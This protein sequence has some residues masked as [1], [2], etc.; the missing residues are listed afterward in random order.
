[1][2][3]PVAERRSPER[4]RHPRSALHTA[5]GE[6]VTVVHL[7]AE[8]YPYARSGGLAEAVA[9]LARH[10]SAEGMRSLA[11]LP[12][13][14]SAREAAGP[15]VALGAPLEVRRNGERGA[16]RARLLWRRDSP[17]GT[18]IC[19]IEHDGYF[20]RERIYGDAH[21]D[22]PDNLE[23]YAFFS[24]AALE[25]LPRLVPGPLL[26]HAH[27][28]HASLGLVYLRSRY[29]SDPRYSGIA[30]VLSVHNAGY[31][32][33][34]P[35]QAM[36]E[37]G[38]PWELFDWR[39]LEWYGKVNVLKG[40]LAFADQ[41]VTV[42]PNHARELRTPGGGFGLQETFI[43]LGPRFSGILN[44]IDRQTWD[45]GSDGQIPATFTS[46]DPAGKAVCKR[47]VQRRFGLREDPRVP[48]FS[49]AARLV[50]QKGL[51][52]MLASPALLG[53][54]A[55]FVFIG[56][57]EA[58]FEQGLHA[59]AARHPDRI[60]VDTNFTDQ[61][62]HLLMAG[63]DFLLMPCQY[64]PC[65]LT[66]MRSQNY[67]AIPVV[68]RVGGLADTVEDGV[69]GFVFEP[70]HADPL[71]GA[72]LRGL[73]CYGSPPEWD[74]MRR[75]AMQRDFGWER[76]VERYLDVYRRALVRASPPAPAPEP[77]APRSRRTRVR[78]G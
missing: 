60:A 58:R 22:Y 4:A 10:Q 67:G 36:V 77:A 1:M 69:T 19:F 56:A 32:G 76:S 14:R 44:G 42:S 50:T 33:H 40:G 7:A 37:L 8:Y 43:W 72:V 71:L 45:P 59:L 48:L 41:V 51:D 46:A 34:Y 6:P 2:P 18:Q 49:M 57:G 27:D 28:W 21:G 68:R 29:A 17:P 5:Q 39:C 54:D 70:Y 52:L 65:G 24:L 66:Q 20:D 9:N 61:L 73:D 26:L 23:R 78:A 38:L 35:P 62:E 13:H 25:A 30:T 12:L 74:R 15:L 16:E 47:E 55:Q 75:N 64:E 11:V 3:D 53:L 63:A 31:Q